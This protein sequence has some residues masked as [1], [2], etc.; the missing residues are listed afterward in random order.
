[1]LWY[2]FIYYKIILQMILFLLDLISYLASYF[3]VLT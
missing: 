3:Q 2:I 1:M